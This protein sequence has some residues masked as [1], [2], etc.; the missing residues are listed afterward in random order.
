MGFTQKYPMIKVLHSGFT[1]VELLIV[2]AIIGVLAVVVLV[3]INPTEQLAKGRDSGR[4]STTTQVG[5][6]I[7]AYY[8]AHVSQPN[9]YPRET[10][11]FV[12]DDD[13]V[14]TG[15][16]STFPGATAY[17]AYGISACSENAVNDYCYDWASGLGSIIYLRMESM[18]QNAK[19]SGGNV[20]WAVFS[21]GDGRGGV[22]CGAVSGLDPWAPGAG[23]AYQ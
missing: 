13:L 6:I 4:I 2:I 10:P 1:L 21:T 15:E 11:S 20:A 19:C 14:S 7:Q 18:T 23:P 8:T 5:R 17:S 3:A 22:V 16:L 12:W 9:P